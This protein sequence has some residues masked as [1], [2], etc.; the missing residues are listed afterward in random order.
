LILL[1]DL[2]HAIRTEADRRAREQGLT[3]AQWLIL[4]R[5]SRTPGLSQRELAELLEVEPISVAR[6]VDRL[7]AHG[8]VERRADA[9][10]RRIWRLHL[11]PEAESVLAIFSV[12]REAILNRVTE[13]VDDVT[14]AF[15]TTALQRMKSN[16]L[17]CRRSHTVPAEEEDPA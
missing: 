10:D 8:L 7:E 5:L 1:H 12:H 6:L 3:R 14:L 11:L 9:N 17:A 13:G 4:A 2:A 16:I 15:V